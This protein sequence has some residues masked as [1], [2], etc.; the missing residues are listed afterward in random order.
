MKGIL[1]GRDYYEFPQSDFLLQPSMADR[2]LYKKVNKCQIFISLLCQ[3]CFCQ[4]CTYI[5]SSSISNKIYF[6]SLGQVNIL[7]SLLII[8]RDTQN[9]T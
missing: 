6:V 8:K 4:I 2:I 1:I 7:H 9:P 5:S 3:I